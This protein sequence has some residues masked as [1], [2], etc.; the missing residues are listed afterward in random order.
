MCSNQLSYVAI[1]AREGTVKQL[2]NQESRVLNEVK[3]G[4]VAKVRGWL[5]GL[6][7]D[8]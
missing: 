8:D 6:K 7:S 5:L 3:T 2:L 4:A 1:G